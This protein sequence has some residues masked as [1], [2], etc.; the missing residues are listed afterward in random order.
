MIQCISNIHLVFSK[1][2]DR[3]ERNTKERA[4]ANFS[5]LKKDLS[6]RLKGAANGL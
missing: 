4:G 2:E 1:G 5:K 3:G 6:A